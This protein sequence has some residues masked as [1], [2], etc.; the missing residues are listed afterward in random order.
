MR[1]Q[2]VRGAGLLEA[3]DGLSPSSAGPLI[4]VLKKDPFV[5]EEGA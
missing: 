4:L 2:G 5:V 1:P 3:E